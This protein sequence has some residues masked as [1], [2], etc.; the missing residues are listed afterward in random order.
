MLNYIDQCE[1]LPSSLSAVRSSFTGSRGCSHCCASPHMERTALTNCGPSQ[2]IAACGIR[3]VVFSE[4]TRSDCFPDATTCGLTVDKRRTCCLSL[5]LLLMIRLHYHA[6]SMCIC[7]SEVQLSWPNLRKTNMLHSVSHHLCP[8]STREDLVSLCSSVCPPVR[9]VCSIL[10]ILNASIAHSLVAT[11]RS[12][13]CQLKAMRKA[14][15]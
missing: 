5:T 10:G 2:G 7:T 12:A 13:Y 11:M 9:F 6:R 1:Q 8:R 4:G 15:Q 3:L 14:E